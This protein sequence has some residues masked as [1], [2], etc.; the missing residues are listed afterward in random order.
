VILL[1][2]CVGE[3]SSPIVW[4]FIVILGKWFLMTQHL[5]F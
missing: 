1:A 4:A 5:F 3:Y 2:L